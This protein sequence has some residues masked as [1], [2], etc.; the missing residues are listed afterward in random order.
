[1][2]GFNKLFMTIVS[3]L[4][5]SWVD[6]RL[7]LDAPAVPVRKIKSPIPNEAWGEDPDLSISSLADLYSLNAERMV[8]RN[9]SAEVGQTQGEDGSV[10]ADNANS[11]DGVGDGA[12]A[13]DGTRSEA[14]LLELAKRSAEY[15]ISEIAYE[16]CG[17]PC[18]GDSNRRNWSRRLGPFISSQV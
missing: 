16:P 12:E 3:G 13:P 18:E 6:T 7:P 15:F 17:L 2:N 9:L 10:D 5:G 8:M 11:V 14:S 4:F 1:M